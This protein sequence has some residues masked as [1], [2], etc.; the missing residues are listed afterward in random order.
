MIRIGPAVHL[1]FE[2]RPGRRNS[3]T[4]MHKIR[5]SGDLVGANR[6]RG[7]DERLAGI[8]SEKPIAFM[9]HR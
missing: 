5:R 6:K 1:F 2:P 4:M 9:K 8:V 7:A 3:G